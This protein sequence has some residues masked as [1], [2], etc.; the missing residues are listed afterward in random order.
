ML[1]NFGTAQVGGCKGS[2]DPVWEHKLGVNSSRGFLRA[3]R[4]L[5]LGEGWSHSLLREYFLLCEWEL[6]LIIP[7]AM[8]TRREA[9]LRRQ[10]MEL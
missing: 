6:K 9:A 1:R 4:T 7:S 3:P 8:E 5:Q 10:Q 2:L